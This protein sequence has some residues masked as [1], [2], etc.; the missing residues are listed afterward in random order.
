[1]QQRSKD[2]QNI[3]LKW[4]LPYIKRDRGNQIL[5]ECLA[6]LCKMVSNVAFAAFQILPILHLQAAFSS[7]IYQALLAP[8][9]LRLLSPLPEAPSA[10]LPDC[11]LSHAFPKLPLKAWASLSFSLCPALPFLALAKLRIWGCFLS[12]AVRRWHWRARLRFHGEGEWSVPLE[13]PTCFLLVN[14]LTH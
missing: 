8:R 12:I 9:I 13:W 10:S 14:D 3:C 11:L 4:N 2:Q 6:L 5:A 1:M 7:S